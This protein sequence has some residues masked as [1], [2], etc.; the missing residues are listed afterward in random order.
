MKFTFTHCGAARQRAGHCGQRAVDGADVKPWN[1]YAI[2]A[3]V[4]AAAAAATTEAG[5]ASSEEIGRLPINWPAP[6]IVVHR[7]QSGVAITTGALLRSITVLITLDFK[8][9]DIDKE[10]CVIFLQF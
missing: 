10:V 7:P 5:A 1:E 4:A 3:Y 8:V 2:V 6:S 9:S